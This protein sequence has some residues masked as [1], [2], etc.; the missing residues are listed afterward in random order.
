VVYRYSL[1]FLIL[2]LSAT[3]GSA[4]ES[5][6][7]SQLVRD[8]SAMEESTQVKL[9]YRD[10]VKR[11]RASV[12]TVRVKTWDR[13]EAIG[14]SF[15]EKRPVPGT[16]SGIV[17]T[18]SGLILTNAHV[19]AGAQTI[20]LRQ[21]GKTGETEA[22]IVGRD[23]ST[24]VAILQAAAGDWQPATVTNSSLVQ[25]GDVV[26][27]VGSPYGLE[28]SVT[29]GIISA[30]G[31]AD[32]EGVGGALQD[33]FQTDAAIH[34]GNSGGP[35]VDG[36]GRVVGMNSAAYGSESIG[37]AIPINLAIKIASDLMQFGKVQRG[38]LGVRLS[39]L[40]PEV[41]QGMG[42]PPGTRGASVTDVN[43]EGAAA[44]AGMLPGDVILEINGLPV[45]SVA[46][47]QVRLAS[48]MEGARVRLTL[49]RAQ[50]T[51]QM[52]AVL[53]AAPDSGAVTATIEFELL[54]GLKVIQ[55]DQKWRNK[56][57]LPPHF[58][59]LRVMSDF[60]DLP[61]NEKRLK[62]GDFILS[63]NGDPVHG[64]LTPSAPHSLQNSKT[65]L[66]MLKVIRDGQEKLIGVPRPAAKP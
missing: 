5:I 30:T 41:I 1:T 55:V 65:P 24:D 66:L 3:C 38:F 15:A 51:L 45:T 63:V 21:P 16:G 44:K 58:H 42:L 49:Q 12:V 9:S 61:N 31:R 11:A 8:D 57:L 22:T 26:L 23:D 35:L 53:D 39:S 40:S 6:L 29:M 13:A 56:L 19:V 59:G 2:L 10:V 34:P 14:T 4:E 20:I 7:P 25:A 33:Y 28:G 37:L 50:E 32:L 48:M 54:P 62:E 47:L 60:G 27:A 36:L 52:E 17:L 43:S 64:A 18:K 46:S